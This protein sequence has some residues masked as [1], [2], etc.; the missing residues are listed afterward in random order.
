MNSPTLE[1]VSSI[2]HFCTIGAVRANNTVKYYT[3][4]QGQGITI[5]RI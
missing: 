3:A 2:G 4:T 1:W 5:G